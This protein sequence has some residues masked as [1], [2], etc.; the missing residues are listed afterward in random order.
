MYCFQRVPT[1]NGLDST[2]AVRCPKNMLSPHLRS[3]LDCTGQ[4]YFS[5]TFII[6]QDSQMPRRSSRL[7]KKKK[8]DMGED[9]MWYRAIG[10]GNDSDRSGRSPP[11]KSNLGKKRNFSRRKYHAQSQG[12]FTE[13]P[14]R[15]RSTKRRL[16]STS[17]K[18]KMPRGALT[19]LYRSQ[20]HQ[21]RFRKAATILVANENTSYS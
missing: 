6:K 15:L 10:A 5:P 17:Q 12:N 2:L 21:N 13:N 9:A 20:V 4:T 19:E 16:I 18:W 8:V 14:L 11:H 3:A 1:Q 7:A